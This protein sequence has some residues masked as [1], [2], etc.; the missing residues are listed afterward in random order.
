V[1]PVFAERF[2]E[3]ARVLQCK[4]SNSAEEKANC[5]RNFARCMYDRLSHQ[6]HVQNDSLLATG[7]YIERKNGTVQKKKAKN[8]AK[9][10]VISSYPTADPRMEF[11]GGYDFCDYEAMPIE[12]KH[13]QQGMLPSGEA[14]ARCEGAK[15]AACKGKKGKA[16]KKW[17]RGKEDYMRTK[18]T[19]NTRAYFEMQD[20]QQRTESQIGDKPYRFEGERPI[21]GQ[22]L[23]NP[24][25]HN[26]RP[27][28]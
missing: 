27:V 6:D 7:A 18:G 8:C 14:V 10:S 5:F 15:I 11:S 21:P 3:S 26:G 24:I 25:M 2:E 17:V 16:K 12:L 13:L 22:Q 19:R 4:Q 1:S 9:D 20:R 28:R 23:D